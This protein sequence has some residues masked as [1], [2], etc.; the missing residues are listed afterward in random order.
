M[1]GHGFEGLQ[2]RSQICYS[3]FQKNIKKN[4]CSIQ[5]APSVHS[6]HTECA[7]G[8]ALSVHSV[9][10]ECTLSVHSVHTKCTRCSE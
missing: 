3:E 6:V 9:H 1:G 4:I 2:L 10:T 7:P 5:F 8:A